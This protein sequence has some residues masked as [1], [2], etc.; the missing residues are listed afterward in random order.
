[1]LWAIDVGNT[2]TVYGL[3][4][5]S[6]YA[7][8]FRLHTNPNTTEDELAADLS[9]LCKLNALEFK[10]EGIVVGSVVPSVNDVLSRFSKEWLGREAVF[11]RHGSQ[12]GVDV[13]YQPPTAVGP[14]RI[15]NAL[16]AVELGCFPALVVDFGTATTFDAIGSQGEYLGGAILPGVNLAFE[17][18]FQKASML[19]RVEFLPPETAIGTTTAAA[20]QSGVVL[21]YSGSIDRLAARMKAELEGN[22]IVIATGGLGAKFVELCVEI[23]RYEPNLTLDGLRVA[24]SRISSS[25]S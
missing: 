9:A 23:E 20:I 11:L 12:V 15:A 19:P 25:S 10:A 13:R 1:M 5:G 22:V 4:D 7:A 18:L 8:Q 24:Y 6:Q 21:G 14:D 16:G 2:H 3:W 17:A